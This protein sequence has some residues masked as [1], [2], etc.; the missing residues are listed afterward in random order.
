MAAAWSGG[1]GLAPS[2]SLGDGVALAEPVHGCAPDIAGKGIANPTAAIL[3]AALLLRHHWG[4]H[5]AAARIETAVRATLVAGAYTADI[6]LEGALGTE[7]F[8]DLVCNQL[9]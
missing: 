6:N 5:E 3:S 9:S 1:L 7:A 2:L 4:R 8:T